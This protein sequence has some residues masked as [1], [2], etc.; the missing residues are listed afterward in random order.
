MTEQERIEELCNQCSKKNTVSCHFCRPLSHHTD[1]F[2]PKFCDVYH[3]CINHHAC[4]GCFPSVEYPDVKFKQ[5]FEPIPE[6]KKEVSFHEQ[7]GI[8]SPHK[9]SYVRLILDWKT[10]YSGECYYCRKKAT[11]FVEIEDNDGYILYRDVCSACV[12]W[13]TP[14]LIRSS[15]EARTGKT[16][17][18]KIRDFS[19]LDN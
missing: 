16:I 8:I 14:D 1:N 2:H 6:K 9:Y 18:Y 15:L 11:L 7:A 4:R 12:P 10:R 13:G 17:D 19:Q 5:Y 3:K